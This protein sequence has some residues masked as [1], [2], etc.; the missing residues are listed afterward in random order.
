[1]RKITYI[2]VL[3]ILPVLF[4]SGCVETENKTGKVLDNA[5]DAITNPSNKI[6]WDDSHQDKKGVEAT[7]GKVLDNANDAIKSS[8]NQILWNK[9]ESSKEKKTHAVAEPERPATNY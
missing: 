5:N 2:I 8:S 9:N 6:I 7:A 3:S 1:M 4:I